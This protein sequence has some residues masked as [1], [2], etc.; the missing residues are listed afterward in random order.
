MQELS[1]YNGI[2]MGTSTKYRKLKPYKY[3]EIN[4]LLLEDI[5]ESAAKLFKEAGYQV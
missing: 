5:N 1:N 4:I 3:G 2:S